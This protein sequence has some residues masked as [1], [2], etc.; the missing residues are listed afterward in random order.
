MY[1]VHYTLYL[2]HGEGGVV[3]LY[4]RVRHLG[5][6]HHREGRHDPVGVLLPDLGD[7]EG[8]HAGPGTASQR[9]GQLEALE[10]VTALGFLP[11]DVQN[12][13]NQLRSL[14]VV[15]LEL[16]RLLQYITYSFQNWVDTIQYRL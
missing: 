13:V 7:Q 9:V 16:A 4:N 6:G 3:W 1:I 12:R 14:R 11:H 5:G 2:V 8:P 15:A 10:T